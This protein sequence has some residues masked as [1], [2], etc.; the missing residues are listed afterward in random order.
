VRARARYS[1]LAGL[2]TAA[3]AA[4]SDEAVDVRLRLLTPDSLLDERLLAELAERD[5]DGRIEATL[6]ERLGRP[7]DPDLGDLGRLL[8]FDPVLS[9]T[10]DNSCSGCHGPNASFNGSKPIEIGIGNN[11]VVGP[12]RRGPHNRR[13][14]PTLINAA[15]Y[16]RL[17][18]DSRFS[19]ASL[20]PFD[21]SR[22][23]EFPAPEG[24]SLSH[25][26]HLLVAQAFTPVVNRVEMAGGFAG[27]NDAMR[28]EIASRVDQVA[29]YRARF[30]RI[31][32][33]IEAGA[34]VGYEHVARALAEFQFT[35]VRA[36][37]PVDRYARGDS[38]ALTEHQKQGALL[39]FGRA[40][41]G[42]CHLVRGH[43]NQMFSDFENHVLGVPQI[44]PTLGNVPFDGPGADEDYGV[45]GETGRD[46]DRYRF[47]TQPL[48]NVALQ[49]SFMHNGA[50]VCL[51]DAIRQHLEPARMAR[52]YTPDRLDETLRRLGPI[53]P[54]LSRLAPLIEDPPELA[55]VELDLVVDFV[56]HGLTDPD[57]APEALRH[58][59]PATVPS[60]L[61]VH[62]FEWGA[63]R[64][65]CG[66]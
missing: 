23:F 44:V 17:M 33:D 55:E 32:P 36:D 12:G 53:E 66:S 6:E 39:F 25:L 13:R 10:R 42:E 40:M 45:G 51:E 7:I 65:A 24:A 54:V 59:V 5:F 31:F 58:L 35:L 57:A 18:W 4:C 22:G 34:A 28:T 26:D 15:F 19:S 60:G 62:D 61:S 21:N 2:A 29:E 14:A 43:F 1:L 20:D 11:G 41:C 3:L 46:S 56:R 48:R 16:P 37:A 47:R 63:R 30:A 8:F 52:S 27:D 38:S 64:S 50:F 49:P 9:L